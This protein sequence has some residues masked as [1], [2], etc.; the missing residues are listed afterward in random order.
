MQHRTQAGKSNRVRWL[1]AVAVCLLGLSV[2]GASSWL[3]S[4]L[5]HEEVGPLLVQ[6]ARTIVAAIHAADWKD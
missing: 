3:H 6:A 2:G 4:K 5:L 1:A